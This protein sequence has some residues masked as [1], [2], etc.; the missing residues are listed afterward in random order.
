[1]KDTARASLRALCICLLAMAKLRRIPVLLYTNYLP[2]K[3]EGY[4]RL[5]SIKVMG[6][7]T[8]Y[9]LYMHTIKVQYILIEFYC[10]LHVIHALKM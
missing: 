9:G 7:Y 10:I 4:F 8:S 3:F 5:I 2:V 1:M 6:G